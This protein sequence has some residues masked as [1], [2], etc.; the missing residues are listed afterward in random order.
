MYYLNFISICIRHFN[1]FFHGV[2]LQN[3]LFAHILKSVS[4]THLDVYKRQGHVRYSTTG[5]SIRDNSQPLVLRYVK[6]SLSIAHNG[7]LTNTA[8]LRRE[9]ER[10]GAIF[11]TTSDS[12]AVSYTHL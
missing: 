6:G 8:A 10:T 5:S 7:N 1:I 12:E 9:L 2:I 4:Y 3:N 11:Q